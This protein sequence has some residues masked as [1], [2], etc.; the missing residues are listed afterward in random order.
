LSLLNLGLER[1]VKCYNRNFINR[2]VFHIEEYEHG[3]KTYNNKVCVKESSYNEFEIDYY[4]KLEKVIELQYH[5]KHNIVFYSNVIDMTLIKESEY[6]IIMV[7]SK[8]IQRLN[9]LTPMMFLFSSSNA[10]KFITN[11]LLSLKRIVQEL[12]G[13]L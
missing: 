13:Y 1:K 2:H 5:S 4:R 12:I 7:W 3:K 6:I 10:N 11:T 9:S 8:L